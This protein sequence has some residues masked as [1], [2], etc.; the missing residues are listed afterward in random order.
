MNVEQGIQARESIL[1]FLEW[2]RET[3][4]QFSVVVDGPNVAYSKQNFETG[5]FSYHQVIE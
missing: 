5:C 3:S 1:N 2:M 4:Q